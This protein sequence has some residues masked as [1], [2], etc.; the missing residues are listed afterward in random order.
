MGMTKPNNMTTNKTTNNV[1]CRVHTGRFS[2]GLE[3]ARPDTVRSHA[4]Q[5]ESRSENTRE[6]LLRLISDHDH[7]PLARFGEV[8]RVNTRIVL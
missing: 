4:R 3:G 2:H 7:G 5:K 6:F 8:F 1:L